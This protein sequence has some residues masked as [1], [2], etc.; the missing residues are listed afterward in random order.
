MDHYPLGGRGGVAVNGKKVNYQRAITVGDKVTVGGIDALF[1][2]RQCRR[3]AAADP[4]PSAPRPPLSA[5]DD[6]GLSHSVSR[7]FCSWSWYTPKARNSPLCSWG[8]SVYCAR[9]WGGCTPCTVCSGAPDS[10]WKAWRSFS[11]RCACASRPLLRFPHCP[12]K[13]FPCCWA[14]LLC[15]AGA[16][17]AGSG[18]CQKAALARGHCRLRLAGL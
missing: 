1:L 14:C 3:T 12:S 9:P 18:H 15:P 2:S 4:A 8:A 11:H 17:P 10:S 16:V 7:A 13:L 5:H 6:A